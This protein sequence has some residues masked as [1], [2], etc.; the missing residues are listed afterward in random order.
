[1]CFDWSFD[2]FSGTSCIQNERVWIGKHGFAFKD[3][4]WI[5]QVVIQ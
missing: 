1:M 2:E 3:D 4:P 5:P